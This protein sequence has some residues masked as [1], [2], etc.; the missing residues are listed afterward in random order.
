MT[1]WNTFCFVQF[2]L[3][4]FSR[5]FRIVSPLL[6]FSGS[7]LHLLKHYLSILD[8]NSVCNTTTGVI[9]HKQRLYY[10]NTLSTIQA[11]CCIATTSPYGAWEQRSCSI[12]TI[13]V[14]PLQPLYLYYNTLH[15]I[16]AVVHQQQ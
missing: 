12:T 7:A 2:I 3:S 6:L 1:K 10:Y 13:V 9:R 11:C 4:V 5:L 16:T 8:T 14:S 15:P